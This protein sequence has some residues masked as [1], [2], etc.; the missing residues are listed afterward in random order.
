VRIRH[1]FH[2]SVILGLILLTGAM[3]EAQSADGSADLGVNIE[4]DNSTPTE[5]AVVTITVTGPNNG[6]DAATNVEITFEKVAGFEVL[7][8]GTGPYPLESNDDN[9]VMKMDILPSG[10][11]AEM[12]VVVEI[13][14]GADGQTLTINASIKADQQD[15]NQGNNAATADIVVTGEIPLADLKMASTVSN[16][17]PEEGDVI[18]LEITVTNDGPANAVSFF[19][20]Y[21]VPP[22]LTFV[23]CDSG[24]IYLPADNIDNAPQANTTSRNHARMPRVYSGMNVSSGSL[25]DE[26]LQYRKIHRSPVLGRGN[27]LLAADSD[28]DY[29]SVGDVVWFLSNLLAG[30]SAKLKILLNVDPGTTGRTIRSKAKTE[31]LDPKDPD[32]SNN[33]DT[34]EIAVGG[35]EAELTIGKQASFEGS[36]GEKKGDKFEVQIIV[37]NSGPDTAT[38]VTVTELL[39]EGLKF[40]SAVSSDGNADY[41]P[42]T[43]VWNVGSIPSGTMIIL[44]I[45]VEVTAE[46]GT[47]ISNTATVESENAVT[48]STEYSFTVEEPVAELTIGKSLNFYESSPKI[49][50]GDEFEVRIEVTNKGPDTANG[51]KV[52]EELPEGLEYLSHRSYSESNGEVGDDGNPDYDPNTGV[53]DLGNIPNG[54]KVI[55]FIMVR[56]TAEAGTEISNTATVESENAV[57][58]SAEYSFTVEKQAADLE[59]KK[60]INNT[61]PKE[62][63]KVEFEI[64]VTNRGPGDATNIR[65]TDYLPDGLNLL[66]QPEGTQRIGEPSPLSPDSTEYVW[67]IGSLANGE[68]TTIIVKTSVV[69]G[70]DDP[71]LSN[72]ALA[73][74][75][76][77]DPNSKNNSA[78]VDFLVVG[79][80]SDLRF[81]SP[82]GAIYPPIYHMDIRDME[83]VVEGKAED[84]SKGVLEHLHSIG[85]VIY[86]GDRIK[87]YRS[88]PSQWEIKPFSAPTKPAPGRGIQRLPGMTPDPSVAAGGDEDLSVVSIDLSSEQD[89]VVALALAVLVDN[90]DIYIVL[91]PEEE[92]DTD[93]LVSM[94]NSAKLRTMADGFVFGTQGDVNGDGGL[95]SND[96]V[97]ILNAVVNQISVLPIYQTAL[98][99]SDLLV[100]YGHP[101]DVPMLVADMDG[102]AQLTS[103]DASVSLQRIVGFPDQA[104]PFISGLRGCNLIVRDHDARGMQ[105]SIDLNDVSDVHSADVILT[106]DAQAFAVTDVSATHSTQDWLFEYGTSMG[107][108]LLKI[109]MAGAK[110]PVSDGSI[111]TIGFEALGTDRAM[112][113]GIAEVRLNGGKLKTRIENLPKTFALLQ[114]Y[115]NPFNPET[116]IPYR[117][118]EKADVTLVIY[119]ASGQVVRRIELGQMMPGHYIN[120]PEAAY[121]DGRN[122]SGE[123]VSSG[124]Y[125][126]Q[127]RAGNGAA[128]KKMIVVR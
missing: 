112:N 107:V 9:Y 3:N 17:T 81:P 15:T 45:E 4:I 20:V 114:N 23:S 65:I 48:Q 80:K 51:V 26:V 103:Y 91:D 50:K 52:N 110:Q 125:F 2:L 6:P 44:T 22:G 66:E 68:S 111:V 94:E 29:Q 128:T 78:R 19:V 8:V 62:G 86:D 7:N 97:L 119:N 74:P 41:D 76:E 108:G 30:T 31:V 93:E 77:E 47:R 109:S 13:E 58:Q 28:D 16:P 39:P 57:T 67:D 54:T 98:H 37:T 113:P 63:E 25:G 5:K 92:I 123:E 24:G 122:A 69:S 42:N 34:K 32:E 61:R 118:S 35:S 85:V 59:V 83:L 46:A 71:R 87:V 126:Y 100:S 72:L 38:G 124:I 84:F 88:K 11:S 49:H 70:L 105:V 102:D 101:H 90:A 73:Y 21:F 10:S 40:V 79:G 33:V 95:A 53:L 106:Y 55:V 75:E 116:W 64:T 82:H 89:I 117:L 60:T 27:S 120:R 56:V 104:P 1:I 121:W 36:A 99:L 43:G 18:E 127:L 96:A 14:E 12:T 115:P